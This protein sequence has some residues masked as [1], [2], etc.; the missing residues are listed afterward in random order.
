MKPIELVHGNEYVVEGVN[1]QRV[2]DEIGDPDQGKNG[3]PLQASCQRVVRMVWSNLPFDAVDSNASLLRAT[4]KRY[5]ARTVFL[6][7]K[8]RPVTASESS[9]GSTDSKK[10]ADD[11]GVKEITVPAEKQRAAM[12]E[13]PA[14]QPAPLWERAGGK[15]SC[16]VLI[17]TK[18]KIAELQ[19]GAQ[20]CEAVPW[21]KFSFQPPVQGGHPVKVKTEVEVKFEPR[22]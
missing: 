6:V 21:A 10:A 18:G 19:T 9:A 14:V 3:Y 4:V 20:L 16:K 12:I 17:D 7:T 15:V 5:P 22:T 8:V 1:A 2:I 11:E 13:G